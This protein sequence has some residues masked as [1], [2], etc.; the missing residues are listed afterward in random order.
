MVCADTQ[1]SLRLSLSKIRH[2]YIVQCLGACITPPNCC[3][4]MELLPSNLSKLIKDSEKDIDFTI[5]H[6]IILGVASGLAF[7]HQS[8]PPIIHRDMK[9]GNILVAL[10]TKFF[11]HNQLD[12]SNNPRIADFGVSREKSTTMTMTRIGTVRY[13]P[14]LE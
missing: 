13:L 1:R 2:P 14:F 12:S 10:C 9:P 5:F 6:K 11:T 3:I 8:N 4:V 7:L